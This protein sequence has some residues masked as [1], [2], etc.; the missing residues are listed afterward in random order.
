MDVQSS[1]SQLPAL[2]QRPAPS[3]MESRPYVPSLYP[4][5]IVDCI[6]IR[7]ERISPAKTEV[8]HYVS[9]ASPVI[10]KGSLIDLFI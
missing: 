4:E 1:T 9:F 2:Y 8:T 10:E 3:L 7:T 6:E 5:D